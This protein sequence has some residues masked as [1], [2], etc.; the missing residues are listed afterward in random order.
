MLNKDLGQK[1][2]MVPGKILL[3]ALHKMLVHRFIRHSKGFNADDMISLGLMT[4]MILSQHQIAQINENSPGIL[5][6]TFITFT[7]EHL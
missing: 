4:L 5:F 6:C 3:R 7:G 1:K 2:R